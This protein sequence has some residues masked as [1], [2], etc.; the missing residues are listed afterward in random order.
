MPNLPDPESRVEQYLANLAEG[1]AEVPPT[2][3][4]RVEKYLD[5]LVKSGFAIGKMDS[6]DKRIELLE[7]TVTKDVTNISKASILDIVT[8]GVAD[9]Y[10]SVGDQILTT[11]NSGTTTYDCPFD[12]VDIR[13]VVNGSGHTVPGMILQSHY[14]LSG[15]QFDASE[16]AYVTESA[17]PA[18]TYNFKI[19]TTG[20]SF[21]SDTYLS[22][23]T[24]ES[25]PSGGQIVLSKSSDIYTAANDPSVWS[26]FTFESPDSTVPIETVS[27][28]TTEAGT[29]LG[30]LASDSLYSTYG[31]NNLQRVAYGYN[32]YSQSAIRQ[33]LNSDANAGLWWTSQ[34]PF[35]RPPQQLSSVKGLKGYFPKDFLD[36]LSPVK[37]T[38][39]LNTV[40]DSGI[41][42]TE[43]VTDTFFLPSIE[44]MYGV[45]SAASVEGPYFP[46]WK[47]TANLSSPG[48]AAN[49]GRKIYLISDTSSVQY[50][51]LRSAYQSSAY[52]AWSVNTNGQINNYYATGA[53]AVTP[54]CVVCDPN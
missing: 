48:N 14:A 33:W 47:T 25:V 34:N 32:R 12:I 50:A 30:I 43:T 7:A 11:Y 35:D 49:N 29:N 46:Y 8:N 17:L 18:G 6:F 9:K 2:P 45:P 3:E 10:F 5:Y 4:S 39:A 51:R 19:G 41:G 52:Y 42:E 37:V 40:S 15:V 36:I 53:H 22:F 26:C 31:T 54:I 13:D 23:T 27:L 44:E 21:V 24:T 20:G 38:T 1:A 16:A 28:S